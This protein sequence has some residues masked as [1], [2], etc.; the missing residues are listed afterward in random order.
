[1]PYHGVNER[2]ATHRQPKILQFCSALEQIHQVH[3]FTGGSSKRTAQGH[4]H[5]LV[6]WTLELGGGDAYS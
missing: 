6:G 1:M 3:N 2:E 5:N 4:L